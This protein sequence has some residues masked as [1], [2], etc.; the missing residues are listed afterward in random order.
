MRHMKSLGLPEAKQ[1]L[2][3]VLGCLDNKDAESV[4]TEATEETSNTSGSSSSKS[5]KKSSKS[6]KSR[7]S[8]STRRKKKEDKLPSVSEI[9]IMALQE[10]NKKVERE[11]KVL[12]EAILG[13]EKAHKSKLMAE[14]MTQGELKP[15]MISEASRIQ[16]RKFYVTSPS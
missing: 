2:Q 10:E 4:H 9:E 8:K 15:F 3:G 6:S 12:M 13:G 7:S 11:K 16:E 5:T 1:K 14:S